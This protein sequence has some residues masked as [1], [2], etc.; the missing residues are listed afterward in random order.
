MEKF[1]ENGKVKIF[2]REAV[3]LNS[4]TAV[5]LI[6][7]LAEHSGRYEQ[8]I[9]RLNQN[10]IS[11]FA[12]DLRG[13]GQSI[14]K[15]GDCESINKVLT[16][17]KCVVDYVKKHFKFE[18][19]GIFGHSVGGLISALFASINN[20]E[21]DFLVL[22]S[23]AVYCPDK[24]KIM[25]IVPYKILPFVKIKKKHSE[26]QEMLEYSKKDKYA[27]HKF[28]IRTVGVFFVEG[29]KL[30]QKKINITC[31]LLLVCG[32]QDILLTEQNEFL[33]FMEK[34]SNKKN[35]FICYEDAKHRI[36]QNDGAEQRM[37]EIISWIKE[38][39]RG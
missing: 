1:V 21:L 32:K 39:K 27:L 30:L 23:P 38:C 6:H 2:V 4:E 7:G 28:S 37:S 19:I 10:G 24:L 17:V 16:D 33:S 25:K 3:A 12:M 35:K 15:R 5:L 11:V 20:N 34:C 29:Q 26:S 8:F 18:S 14:S 9:E 36:V 22:S 31:P 13:H